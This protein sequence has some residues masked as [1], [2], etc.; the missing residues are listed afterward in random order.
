MMHRVAAMTDQLHAM[1]C[2]NEDQMQPKWNAGCGNSRNDQ[3]QG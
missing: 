3:K 1:P 2:W